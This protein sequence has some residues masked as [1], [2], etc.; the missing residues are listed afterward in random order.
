MPF[1]MAGWMLLQEF[2]VRNL[3]QVRELDRTYLIKE[4]D[5]TCIMVHQR[6]VVVV[7]IVQRQW[8]HWQD[9]KTEFC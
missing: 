6:E 3:L 4:L 1:N 8:L 2:S 5:G 9:Y 7:E